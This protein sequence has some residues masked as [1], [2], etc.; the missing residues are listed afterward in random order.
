MIK[1]KF[2]QRLRSR[3]SRHRS[4]RHCVRCFVITLRRDS[5]RHMSWGLKRIFEA[6]LAVG[7]AALLL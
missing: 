4:M 1:S 5:V 3:T 6:A 2:G 7:V